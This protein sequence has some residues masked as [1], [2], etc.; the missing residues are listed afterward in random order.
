MI[1]LICAAFL[2]LT[3]SASQGVAQ[4][5][6][7]GAVWDRLNALI[8]NNGGDRIETNSAPIRQ[9]ADCVV[10]DADIPTGGLGVLKLE[11]LSWRG[12]GMA[13]FTKDGLPPEQLLLR[14]KGVR[15]VPSAPEHVL[16]YLITTPSAPSGLDVTVSFRWDAGEK[17]LD[18]SVFD[19]RSPAENAVFLQTQIEAVDLSSSGAMQMSAGSAVVQELHLEISP[20][21]WRD[22]NLMAAI[23]A[24]ALRR[25]S[26]PIREA[27]SIKQKALGHIRDMPLALVPPAAQ[28]A[29]RALVADLPHPKGYLTLKMAASP[30]L[31]AARFVPLA[32][33]RG[34]VDPQQIWTLM[35]GVRFDITYD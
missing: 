2:G 8:S 13:R 11:R 19:A 35:D 31:G 4:P 17:Q 14:A 15:F 18:V 26:N 30:G 12:V 23:G 32:L 22:S 16:R 20:E 33:Q 9:G 5:V 7:C 34:R 29:L 21:G 28:G 3:L 10:H 6:F 1:R 27:E 25:A 24:D